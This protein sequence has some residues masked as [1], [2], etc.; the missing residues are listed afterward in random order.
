VNYHRLNKAQ[1]LVTTLRRA[2]EK[3]HETPEETEDHEVRVE[4]VRRLAQ[5]LLSVRMAL[6]IPDSQREI[7]LKQRG[8]GGI[9]QEFDA[10][11]MCHEAAKRI[12]ELSQ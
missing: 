1:D 9:L 5:R 8:V 6:V 7:R 4:A 10:P 11:P 12:D 2:I 3:L